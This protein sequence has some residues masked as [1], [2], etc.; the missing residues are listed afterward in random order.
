LTLEGRKGKLNRKIFKH[1][2]IY[3]G[4][5]LIIKKRFHIQKKLL[6]SQLIQIHCLLQ[7]SIGALR[8]PPLN[9]PTYPTI[10]GIS[11]RRII[12]LPLLLRGSP[13]VEG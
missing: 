8:R 4:V 9:L 13:S 5:V 11:K 2:L 1:I 10:V 3:V 7:I 12:L 6:R